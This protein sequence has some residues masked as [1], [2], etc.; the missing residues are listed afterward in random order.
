MLSRLSWKK[1][2]DVK[3]EN[4]RAE[5]VIPTKELKN[6]EINKP[7]DRYFN[8][9]N[10]T[11]EFLSAIPC[12]S[13][14]SENMTF[15][16]NYKTSNANRIEMRG[17]IVATKNKPVTEKIDQNVISDQIPS[18]YLV[19]TSTTNLE[20]GKYIYFISDSERQRL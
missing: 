5:Q 9:N 7:T 17:D 12:A 10:F 3:N 14:P 1:K 11:P 19:Q 16:V 6:E 8:Q 20:Q 2:N 15:W 18:Q 4:I 13:L